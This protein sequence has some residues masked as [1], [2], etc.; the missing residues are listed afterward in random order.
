MKAG[1]PSGPV[2][3]G[4]PSA[5]DLFQPFLL[6]S[7]VEQT[8]IWYAIPALSAEPW[9]FHKDASGHPVFTKPMLDMKGL[10]WTFILIFRKNERH[11]VPERSHVPDPR[12]VTGYVPDDQRESPKPIFSLLRLPG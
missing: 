7:W 2:Q 11:L 4:I 12:S 6:R 3:Q 10:P 1:E 9:H 5:K 8:Y